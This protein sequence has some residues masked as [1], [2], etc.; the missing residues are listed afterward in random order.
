[1]KTHLRAKVALSNL[2]LLAA[3]IGLSACGNTSLHGPRSDGATSD[4][5]DLADSE[6][7]ATGGV[8]GPGGATGTGGVTGG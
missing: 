2:T 4:A 6:W 7:T 3:V 1:M 5:S 8:L